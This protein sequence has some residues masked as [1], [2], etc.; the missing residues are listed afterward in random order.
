MMSVLVLLKISFY[1]AFVSSGLAVLRHTKFNV[2]PYI[3]LCAFCSSFVFNGLNGVTDTFIA[4]LAAGFAAAALVGISHRKGIHGYL[5]IVIPVIYCMGP[6]GAMYKFFLALFRKEFS[7][8]GAQLIYILKDAFGLRCGIF[9][10]TAVM[11]KI[12]GKKSEKF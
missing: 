3:Y 8:L 1:S 6:G 9:L 7:V 11:N 10:A 5:F 12:T 2:L 4:G